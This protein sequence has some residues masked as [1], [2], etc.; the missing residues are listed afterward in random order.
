MTVTGKGNK[1]E[2]EQ[3]L[4]PSNPIGNVGRNA[5]DFYSNHRG[6]IIGAGVGATLLLLLLRFWPVHKHPIFNLH[7]LLG[8]VSSPYETI[9]RCKL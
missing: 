2:D 3:N 6:E 8:K 7:A 4:R 9:I 5:N 1:L